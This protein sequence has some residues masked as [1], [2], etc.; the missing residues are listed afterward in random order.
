ML[1][2]LVSMDVL[3]EHK[4]ILE[5]AIGENKVK[6]IQSK[7]LTPED[8]KDVDVIIGNC[9]PSMLKYCN[10]LKYIQL[11]NAGTE[12]FTA[13]G[14]IPEG[15]TLVNASGAYG[16]AISE[17]MIGA[18]LMLMKKI[19]LY[20]LNQIEH[21]WKDEG[22]VLSIQD[23]KT[24][25]VGFGDIG[26]EFGKRMSLLG[27]SVKG[28][29]KNISN[30]PEF[31]DEL[32]TM[33]KF[34]ELLAEADIV[35]NCLPGNFETYKIYDKKAFDV[36]KPGAIFVNIGRGMSVDTDAI[37]EALNSG[38]LA[39]AALDV[40]DPE[41]LPKDHPLWDTK[42]VLITPHVSGGYHIKK[43]HDQ[44]IVLAARNIR[45]FL[46][47]EALENIVDMKTGYRKS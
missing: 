43:T 18:I 47:G 33:D 45:H 5:E 25:V 44:I 2:F 32:A 3:E 1:Q 19:D 40:T 7:N 34:Y 17:H 24:L 39:G 28:I 20:R 9:N 22:Q 27:S 14:V 8:M 30:K 13:D 11:N 6:Y 36:M 23:S 10:R 31:L 26:Y 42:N 35:A 29:R 21:N 37:M 16:L 15:A 41:P 12:G 46:N 4:P 38:K